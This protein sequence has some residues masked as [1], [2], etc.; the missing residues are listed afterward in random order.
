MW[1][2]NL[3]AL[4]LTGE[5]ILSLNTPPYSAIYPHN[6]LS[7]FS[8][9][10]V[11]LR[12]MYQSLCFISCSV[13]QTLDGNTRIYAMPFSPTTQVSKG[14]TMWQLSFPITETAA[15]ELGSAGGKTLLEEALKR[16]LTHVMCACCF[17]LKILYIWSVCVY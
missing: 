3:R 12:Y 6:V 8:P 11:F 4:T 10:N 7:S 15:K 14:E 9:H 5:Y 16:F 2:M 1:N 13:F 17:L